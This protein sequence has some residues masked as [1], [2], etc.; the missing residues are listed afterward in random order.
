MP[1]MRTTGIRGPTSNS[2]ARTTNRHNQSTKNQNYPLGSAGRPARRRNDRSGAA[3]LHYA[4][5]Q[6]QAAEHLRSL[7]APV[8]PAAKRDE[9]PGAQNRL[10]GLHHHG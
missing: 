7:T 1:A 5:V 6:R 3:R 10:I 2:Y 9:T 8:P 4:K